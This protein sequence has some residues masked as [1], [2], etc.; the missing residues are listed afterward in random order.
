MDDMGM[1]WRDNGSMGGMEHVSLPG[2]DHGAMGGMGKGGGMAGMDMGNMNMRDE[3]LAPP[4]MKV[5]VGVDMISMNPQDSAGKLGLGLADVGHKVLV[6]TDLVALEP[7]PDPRPPARSL[8]TPMT[9]IG[10]ASCRDR[11]CQ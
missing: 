8:E 10:N 6:Y 7:N 4:D 11:M 2:M 3:S 9:A 5:G 1:G